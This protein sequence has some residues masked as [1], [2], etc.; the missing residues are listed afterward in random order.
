MKRRNILLGGAAVLGA[1][2]FGAYW[3]GLRPLAVPQP[4]PVG[5]T[6]SEPELAAARALLARVPLIDAHAHPGRTFLKD[7]ENLSPIL[8]LYRWIGGTFE[9]ETIA[10][11]REAG[12]AGAVFNG[13]GDVQLLTMGN[14]GLVAAREFAPGEAWASYRRQI[15]NLRALAADGRVLL[16]L[17]PEDVLVAHDTHVPGAILAMEGADALDGD[18]THVPQMFDDGIRMLTLVHYHDNTLGHIMTGD[19]GGLTPFGRETVVALN[20]AG[21]MVD[22]AHASEQTAFDAIAASSKPVVL[23]H[24]H[25]NSPALTHPRFVSPEL[26]A[27]V[28]E[29][30]GYI[31][32]WPAGIGITTLDQFADRV[33][34]LIDVMGPDHVALGSDMDANYRPVLETYAKMPLLVGALQ[35]RGLSDDVLTRVLGGNVLRVW[36][37]TLAA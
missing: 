31:G 25:V 18:L 1:A 3:Y 9:D 7:A 21:I 19:G 32:A 28:A 16:C 20:E 5:F 2:G 17:T 26:A 33:M 27:A 37:N 12:M 4:A 34:W 22:L 8:R 6:L 35:R 29:T 14:G 10:A 23:S 24:T 13:V 11:M 36:R 30:G 15:A